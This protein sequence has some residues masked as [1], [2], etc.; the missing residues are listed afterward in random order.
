M[1]H[2]LYKALIALAL[3][4]DAWLATLIGDVGNTSTVSLAPPSEIAL[5]SSVTVNITYKGKSTTSGLLLLAPQSFHLYI[6]DFIF[7]WLSGWPIYTVGHKKHCEYPWH[8]VTLLQ[9]HRFK[10]C[11]NTL[12]TIALRLVS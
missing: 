9:I 6:D 2:C 7:L 8:S 1:F 3:H 10:P 12:L 4:H 11:E 5:I